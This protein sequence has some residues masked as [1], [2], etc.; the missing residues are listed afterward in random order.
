ML[1]LHWFAPSV[2][3][4]A[5]TAVSL[6]AQVPVRVDR[7]TEQSMQQRQAVTGSLRA[8]SRGHLA[9]LEAGKLVAL[10]VEE[11]EFVSKGERLAQIDDRRLAAQHAAAEA[12][13]L[14]AESELKGYEATA[15]R[16]KADLE[17]IAELIQR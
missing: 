11:G 3:L 6:P 9:A 15:L 5:A 2:I 14:V 17:R 13:K 8:V 12:E 10:D 16:A 7:V 4:I 1:Q